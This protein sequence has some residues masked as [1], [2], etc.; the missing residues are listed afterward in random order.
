MNESILVRVDGE[1]ESPLSLTM[2]DFAAMDAEHQIPDVSQ[3]VPNRQGV[4]VTIEGLLASIRPTANAKYLGLHASAD[5]FHASVPLEAIR[6][7]AVFIYQQDGQPLSASAGGPL[8]LFIPNHA[9]CHADEVDE[10]ANVKFIDRIE[11]TAEKGFDNRPSDD[12][13]H[14]RLH[15]NEANHDHD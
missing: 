3:I 5:D 2:D 10:C 14:E 9:E 15:A 11:L 4:A 6:P 8:R 12:E 13:E 7:Q 1:V